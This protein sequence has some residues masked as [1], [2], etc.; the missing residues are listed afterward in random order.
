MK[1]KRYLGMEKKLA[2]QYFILVVPGF[3]IFT[4]GLIIPLFLSFRYSLTDWDGMSAEHEHLSV[5]RI[6]SIC[7]MTRFELLECMVVYR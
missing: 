1:E 6:M 4:V 3:L 2:R 5:C 7:S